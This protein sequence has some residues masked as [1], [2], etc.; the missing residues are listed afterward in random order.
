MVLLCFY[1][2][3]DFALFIL[4]KVLSLSVPQCSF[5]FCEQMNAFFVAFRQP[6]SMFHLIREPCFCSVSS[7]FM[8]EPCLVLMFDLNF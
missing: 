5:R 4:K 3:S 2:H 6:H 7:R 1:P 8:F